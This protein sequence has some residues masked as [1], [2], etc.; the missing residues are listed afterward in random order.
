MELIIAP[1]DS[2]FR[3]KNKQYKII[4]AGIENGKA[5]ASVNPENE[6]LEK[7]I[8]KRIERDKGLKVYLALGYHCFIDDYPQEIK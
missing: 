7:E 4:K 5:Y 8:I 6:D 2:P 3:Y 1:S